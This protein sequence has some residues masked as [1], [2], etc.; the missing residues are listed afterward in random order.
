MSDLKIFSNDVNVSGKRILVRLDLNVPIQNS[1][2]D[3]GNE[4]AIGGGLYI[5]NSIV[6]IDSTIAGINTLTQSYFHDQHIVGVVSFI[7][8]DQEAVFNVG[9]A[10]TIYKNGNI[11]T[12]GITSIR[13]GLVVGDTTDKIT[14]G[15]LLVA[16]SAGVGVGTI[17][18]DNGTAAFRATLLVP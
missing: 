10:A 11:R 17:K 7:S 9:T 15:G 3:D 5:N 6:T 16:T 18:N 12:T 2:I 1:K 8:S 14:N 4:A 13:G